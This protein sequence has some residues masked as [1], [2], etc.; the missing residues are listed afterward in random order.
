MSSRIYKYL[1]IVSGV[2]CSYFFL[3]SI[4]FFDNRPFRSVII[5][6]IVIGYGLALFTAQIIAEI[7]TTKAN[8]WTTMY[9]LSLPNNGM[10]TRAACALAFPGPVNTPEEAMYWK[11]AVDVKG[12]K[13]T[14]RHQYIMHFNADGL[15][16]N[17][18]FWS[19]T[20][21]DGNNRFV[22]NPLNRYSVSSHSGLVTNTDGS[23]DIYIQNIAPKDGESNWLPAPKDDFILWFRVYLPDQLILDGKYQVPEVIEVK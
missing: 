4:L 18:A 9:K 21:G 5:Q 2:I 19:L 3:R 8:G 15:P 6:G 12:H 22:D 16:P 23:L 20:I 10:L 11:S 1:I 13:L 14:G 17:A 7:K